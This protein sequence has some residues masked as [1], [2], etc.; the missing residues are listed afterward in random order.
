[1]K[2]VYL[3]HQFYPEFYTGT[4]KFILNLSTMM[5]KA[6]NRVKIIS[7]SSYP[8]SFY[9]HSRGEFLCKDYTY[10]GIPVTAL[11]HKKIPGDLNHALGNKALSEIAGDLINR[12][13][14]NVV[15]VGH[16]LRVG[17]LAQVLQP[18]GTPYIVTLTDFFLVCPKVNLV[19][20]AK[21]LCSGPEQGRTCGKL[22]PE[23]ELDYITTRLKA[24]KEILSHARL[25]VAPSQFL[26]GI[27]R[28]EFP[29]LEV[30]I[31]NHG[32]NFHRLRRNEKSYAPHDPVVFCY[33]GSFNGYKGTHLLVEAFKG[34]RSANALLKIYGSGTEESYVKDL[35]AMAQGDGRI[36][37]CG[38][39]PEE[40]TGEILSGVDVIVIPSLCYESYSMILHEALASNVPV[41]ATNLGGLAE[42]IE[43]GVNG[44]L[45][46]SG[47]TEQL[48][49]VLQ[50]I[51]DQP[52]TLSPLK[53]NI[54]KMIIPTV[55]QE[56]YTYSRV[57]QRIKHYGG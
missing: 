20:S 33:A 53:R 40:K 15:H 4:E 55:E 28:K 23:L 34:V 56:A 46:T 14:P 47:D 24:A 49:T 39:Y 21:I 54:D 48:R 6:G 7:Y 8:D 5:Q 38:V 36:E 37:F 42:K 12:E 44:F 22:C 16:T 30:K 3:I 29:G 50:K 25:V 27:F 18:L 45:F 2:I 1:M 52:E 43:D 10:Q 41:V 11:R 35:T 19:T 51:V 26:A 31:I 17:A 13:K 57:Y 9:D 32:L